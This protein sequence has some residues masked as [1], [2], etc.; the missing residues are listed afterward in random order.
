M[1][2]ECKELEEMSSFP[3]MPKPSTF[4]G[5]CLGS[6]DGDPFLIKRRVQVL[7]SDCLESCVVMDSEEGPG[8][9]RKRVLL[10]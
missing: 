10:D 4:L 1:L 2:L 8:S 7:H 9:V 5:Y 6:R 3:P